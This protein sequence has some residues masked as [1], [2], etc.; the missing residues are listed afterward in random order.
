M[1]LTDE[2]VK[3]FEEINRKAGVPLGS[4]AEIMEIA[5]GLADFLIATHQILEKQN[6]D[7]PLEQCSCG[8]CTMHDNV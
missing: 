7:N 6:E 2:Q 8:Q 3:K 4:P 5:K 1:Q